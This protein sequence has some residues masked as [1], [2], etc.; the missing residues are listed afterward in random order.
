MPHDA[1]DWLMIVFL[2]ALG[3]CAGSFLNVVVFRLPAIEIPPTAGL[4]EVAR[5]QLHGLSFP[6]SH[7]PRCGYQLRWYDNFPVL[8]WVWL[9]GKCRKCRLPISI[10][11]LIIEALVGLVFAGFYVTFFLLGPNWGP[12]TPAHLL[13]RTVTVPSALVALPVLPVEQVPIPAELLPEGTAVT[14]VEQAG[15]IRF[16]GQ[17]NLRLLARAVA[18]RADHWPMLAMTLV[19]AFCLLAAALIDAR[20]YFIPRSLS[21][22]PAVVG[23]GVHTV[24]DQ[25]LAPLSVMVGPAGCAWAV[26]LGAGLL[27]ALALVR[28]GILRR[29]FA[30]EMPLLEVERDAAGQEE[31]TAEEWDR[32]RRLTRREMIREVAFLALPIGL[33]LL[34]ALSA[35]YGP[36]QGVWDALAG[37]RP[38][39]AFLGSLLGGLIGGGVIWLVRVLGSLGFGREAMG[40]GDADLMFGVGCCLGAGP[41]GLALFPAAMIGLAFAIYRWAARSRHEMPFGPHLAIASLAL[42]VGWNQLSDYLMPSLVVLGYLL[43]RAAP[44]F[45]L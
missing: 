23:L 13:N 4:L 15:P 22:I 12:P 42:V 11:Y 18:N 28:W 8:G 20:H 44:L 31:P 37:S 29:S 19:L 33:G 5:R 3:A 43:G 16:G 24:H 41:A 36:G 34:C 39:S 30:E 14:H 2:F 25:R 26:G 35:A 9:G 27:I 40:L 1:I 38:A 45:G 10:Q 7:C 17:V 21:Y 6:P 32:I